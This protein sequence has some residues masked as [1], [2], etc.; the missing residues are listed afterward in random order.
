MKMRLFLCSIKR[1]HLP[2]ALN[3]DTSPWV[4]LKVK[5]FHLLRSREG[6]KSYSKQNVLTFPLYLCQINL[7]KKKELIFIPSHLD[8]RCSLQLFLFCFF[9]LKVHNLQYPALFTGYTAH[10]SWQFKI[11]YAEVNMILNSWLLYY[12]PIWA[13]GHEV[14]LQHFNI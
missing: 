11:L 5:C 1:E 2:G 7:A 4:I 6:N 13:K 12:L 3:K 10:V 14:Q 8:P 9:F